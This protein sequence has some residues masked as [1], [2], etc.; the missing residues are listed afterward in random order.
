VR[1]IAWRSKINL[2]KS[3]TRA[4]QP[5]WGGQSNHLGQRHHWKPKIVAPGGTPSGTRS[6]WLLWIS[7]PLRTSSTIMETKEKSKE[8]GKARV[9]KKVIKLMIHSVIVP[10]LATTLYI[11]RVGRSRLLRN[12]F[13]TR[14]LS[15]HSDSTRTRG[16]PR[17][18][19]P[20]DAFAGPA[21]GH[22]GLIV[23]Q[24]RSAG[25]AWCGLTANFDVNNVDLFWEKNIIDW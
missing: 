10:Q 11:Y 8:I 13:T 9:W 2:L 12:S 7:G 21:T 5:P 18:W 6:L 17:S 1:Q 22:S 20:L 3:P 24:T 25:S 23:W 16:T 19:E 4:G 14:D 15:C